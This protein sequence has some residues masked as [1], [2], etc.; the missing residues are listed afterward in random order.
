M[1]VGLPENGCVHWKTRIGYAECGRFRISGFAA[2]HS[3]TQPR[4]AV[5]IAFDTV[6]YV[7]KY[8]A[9]RSFGARFHKLKL[10]SDGS[11]EPVAACCSTASATSAF[12][13][14]I[15]ISSPILVPPKK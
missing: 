12:R 15:M 3:R 13:F 14:G 2:N 8:A 7:G 5:C 10:M 11:A 6:E 9:V 1:L 4:S